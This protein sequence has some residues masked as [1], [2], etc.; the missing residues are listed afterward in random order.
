[1]KI[2]LVDDSRATRAMERNILELLGH[3]DVVEASDGVEALAAFS[4]QKPDLVLT[5]W[6]MPKMDGL[7]L[8]RNIRKENT[9]T[10]IIIVITGALESRVTEAIEA[11]A[12][13]YIMKPFMMELLAVKI[14]ETMASCGNARQRKSC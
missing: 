2:L 13:N 10:P 5:D 4:E 3:T 11:G 14:H 9:D 6:M 8:T 7:A 12:N 1:M